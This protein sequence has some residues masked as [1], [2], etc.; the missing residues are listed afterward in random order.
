MFYDHSVNKEDT[1]R[2]IIME[3]ERVIELL[4]V[5]VFGAISSALAHG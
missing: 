2:Y 1:H 5:H 4:L 3:F